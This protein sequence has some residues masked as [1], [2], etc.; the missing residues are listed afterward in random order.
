MTIQY[1]ASIRSIRDEKLVGVVVGYG[2]LQWGPE[3]KPTAVYLVKVR[4]GSTSLG[5][6]CVVMDAEMTVEA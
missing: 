6:A 1:G 2:M 5:P 4:E 3:D